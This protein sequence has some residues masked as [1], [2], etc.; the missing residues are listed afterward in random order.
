MLTGDATLS[1]PTGLSS[2]NAGKEITLIVRQ[3]DT[4]AHALSFG[5]LWRFQAGQTVPV[6]GQAPGAV[7]ILK[8]K[9]AV[10]EG[11]LYEGAVTG[12]VAANYVPPAQTYAT[13]LNNRIAIFGDSRAAN[14]TEDAAI[15]VCDKITT[16]GFLSWAMQQHNYRGV[17]AGNYGLNGSTLSDMVTRLTTQTTT[18]T[19]RYNIMANDAGIVVFIGGVNDGTDTTAFQAKYTQIFDT[20]INAGKIVIAFNEMPNANTSGQGAAN[21]ARRDYIDAFVPTNAAKK[22]QYIV[23]NTWDTLAASARST[24]WNTAYIEAVDNPPLHPNVNGARVIG[25]LVGNILSTLLAAYPVRNTLPGTKGTPAGYFVAE[26]FNG[27]TGAP[28]VGCTGQ[29]ATDWVSDSAPAGVTVAFSKGTDSNGFE[30]QIVT[31]GGT[32]TAAAGANVVFQMQ[33]VL[34]GTSLGNSGDQAAAVIRIALDSG[35][36]GFYQAAPY[37]QSDNFTNNVYANTETFSAEYAPPERVGVNGFKNLSYDYSVITPQL[38]LGSQWTAAG[39]KQFEYNIRFGFIGGQAVTGTF[40]LS[41]AGIQRTLAPNLTIARPFPN[42]TA[43]NAGAIKPTSKTQTQ[44]DVLVQQRYDNWKAINLANRCGNYLVDFHSSSS[45]AVSEGMGYGMLI[46]V[47]MAGYD[48]DAKTYFDGLYATTRLHPASAQ[49]AT[50]PASYLMGYLIGADCGTPS[51]YCALDGDMDIA[52]AL[53]MANTQWGSSTGTYNYLAEALNIIGA[54]KAFTFNSGFWSQGGSRSANHSRVSDY[55]MSHIRAFRVATGDT[56]WDSV[57]T[58]EQG[59][60][61]NIQANNSPT[62]GLLPDWVVVDAT[63]SRPSNPFEVEGNSTDGLYFYN[64]CRIPWRVGSDYVITGDATSKSIATKFATFF[65]SEIALRGTPSPSFTPIQGGYRLDG[66]LINAVKTDYNFR[67]FTTP[68]MVAGMVDSTHQTY[69]N[70]MFD[71][72]YS[73]STPSGYFVTELNLLSLLVVTG[74][75]WTP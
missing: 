37:V 74:N 7:T 26:M 54:L 28:G 36:F 22:N 14:S 27:T 10:N 21:L 25:A 71:A 61:T 42:H 40:R 31:F 2:T 4:G 29:L 62:T 32:S 1:N 72:D 16:I 49:T 65:K 64:A 34:Q 5:T 41:R 6:V 13:P 69:L 46:T 51:P 38:T 8:W 59:V 44:M 57:R 55:M 53:L 35:S 58:K 20:L 75:W 45:A 70:Q 50:P 23:I 43:Y 56:F 17:A 67:E 39:S 24:T 52:M 15:F 73:G 11:I 60:M 30:Q 33:S 48:A 68:A 3:D 19:T 9:F 66:S 47:L 63:S 18:G 12:H